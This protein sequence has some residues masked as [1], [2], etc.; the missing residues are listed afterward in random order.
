MTDDLPIIFSGAMVRAIIGGQKTQTRR[1]V[2]PQPAP[3][4]GIHYWLGDEKWLP[5]AERTPRRVHWEAWHGAAYQQRASGLLCGSVSVACPYLVG[6]RLWVKET[7]ECRKE[8]DAMSPADIGKL[9][10]SDVLYLADQAVNSSGCRDHFAWGRTR[11]SIHM[12]R[13]ASRLTLEIVEVRVQRVQEISEAD[14]VAESTAQRAMESNAVLACE[15]LEAFG[16]LWDSIHGP[17]T[18]E[19]N[20]WVWAITFRRLPAVALCQQNEKPQ[21]RAVPQRMRSTGDQGSKCAEVCSHLDAEDG[22]RVP[23]LAGRQAQVGDAQEVLFPCQTQGTGG[24]LAVAGEC[25]EETRAQTPYEAG[26]DY[27][28]HGPNLVN[29]GFRHFG[30]R[31]STA[32]WARGVREERAANSAIT[33][34]ELERSQRQAH[35]LNEAGSTP[36]PATNSEG[37]HDA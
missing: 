8:F 24:D 2:R 31:E 3:E 17:G 37:A 23:E 4:F 33:R 30:S 16:K 27:V 11:S 35:N 13:W 32:E 14:A 6:R 28:R 18:F 26:R 25:S 36:V 1:I 29:C 9:Q 15:M 20:D 34:G 21:R 7:F 5:R 19:R 12:P 22:G 10:G